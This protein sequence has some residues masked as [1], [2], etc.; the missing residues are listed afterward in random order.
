[1]NAASLHA[2]AWVG[3]GTLS[4][5]S[6]RAFLRLLMALRNRVARPLVG[7]LPYVDWTPRGRDSRAFDAD[8]APPRKLTKDSPVPR[9]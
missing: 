6:L 9:A 3:W 8:P 4:P 2:L 5:R 1:M 7:H